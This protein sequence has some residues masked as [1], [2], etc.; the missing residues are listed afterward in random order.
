MPQAPTPVD[1]IEEIIEYVMRTPENINANILR[2]ML[3]E[4]TDKPTGT[5]E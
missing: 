5:V 2:E 4:L 1:P 3:T